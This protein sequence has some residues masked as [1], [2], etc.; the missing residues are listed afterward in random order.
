MLQPKITIITAVYNAEK[1]L[2]QTIQSVICQT[3]SNIEYIIVDGGSKD[4]TVD[5]IRKYNDQIA[6]WVS[7]PDSGIYDAFNKG[8]V[9]ATGDYVQ[10]L[11]SD[12]CLCDK[13]VIE[14][15]A[16]QIECDVDILSAGVWVVDETRGLQ[17]LVT[18]L[19][20]TESDYN[21]TMIPHQ[22]MFVRRDLLLKY[23]FDTSYRIAAD[24]LFFLTCYYDKTVQFRYIAFPVAFYS[25]V[26]VSSVPSVLLR[27]ENNRVRATFGL[28][29]RM[30]CKSYVKEFVKDVL[31]QLH[32]FELIR[33]I[34]DRYIHKTWQPHHCN[35]QGCR[36]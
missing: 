17:S 11:G 5:L 20:A 4:R 34:L 7:E 33:Y 32:L 24:Y 15:I 25:M 28:P 9:H 2:E 35:W 10:F 19:K 27:E 26:G 29:A 31:K 14:K 16:N 6:Y 1:T 21:H 36:W 30:V 3:Y 23:P 13:F 12:D 8:V 22:G 18:G